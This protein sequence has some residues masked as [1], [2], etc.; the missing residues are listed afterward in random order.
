MCK[1]R[2]S[3]SCKRLQV[4]IT[5]QLSRTVSLKRTSYI[6]VEESLRYVYLYFKDKH[7]TTITDQEYFMY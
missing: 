6:R 2:P 3:Q 1:D 4:L 7:F 5:T